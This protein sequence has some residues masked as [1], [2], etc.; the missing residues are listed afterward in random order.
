MLFVVSAMGATGQ[1]GSSCANPYVIY[2]A[3]NCNNTC[4]AQYCG[5]MQCP[6]G[7][8]DSYV[9]AAG[10]SGGLNPG[11]TTDNE[12]TQNV[13]WLAVTATANNFTINNGSPYVGSGASTANQ[14]DYAVYSGTCGSLTQ[15]AC[16]TIAA[17]SSASV[18]GLTAGQVYY[19]MMSPPAGNTTA[20]ATNVCIT[21]TVGYAAPGNTCATA[22]SLAT[23]VTYVYTNAGSTAQ[24]P[25]CSGS[26]E[27]DVW[28]Q[29][30]APAN[31]PAG[32][33]AY[34]SVF[35][36]VCN[37][38]QG[39]QLS[40]WNTNNTCP[41]SSASPTVVCQNPGVLTQYY[42]QWTAVAN[43][44]YLI[45]LDGFAGT[46]CRYSITVGSNIVLPVELVKFDAIQKEHAVHLE[47][48][49]ASEVNNDYFT[50]E[51]GTDGITFEPLL[52]VKG[53]GT[54][55]HE[56][57]YEA[58]D[59]HPLDGIS[60][61][62]LRQTDFDGTTG[63]SETVA[64]NRKPKGNGFRLQPNPAE[65][66]VSVYISGNPG[67]ESKIRLIDMSGRTLYDRTVIHQ[68]AEQTVNLDLR[69]FPAGVYSIQLDNGLELSSSRLVK[70]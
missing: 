67:N 49:T 46:A 44:C 1:V 41:A 45:T 48:I 25:L 63:F 37:S 16:G 30:C 52:R 62:R 27:N 18:T 13:V 47:W 32:Q 51:R 35:N 11:C 61:Y 14:R 15:L 7:N 56:L 58:D 9:T 34:V 19:V 70:R 53:A 36:Q 43:Q 22:V 38:T 55:S 59:I 69:T 50:V 8:C 39:L 54:V 17:N 66:A 21:S 40:V 10:S 64:V 12:T 31:W 33:Q 3:T 6:T 26:V 5:N 65:E 20:N 42:Y 57:H 24:G 2:P 60:Y 28:Y 23:N 68:A 29:W 4:G